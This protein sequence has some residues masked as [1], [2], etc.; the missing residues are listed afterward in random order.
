MQLSLTRVIGEKAEHL[1]HLG[2]THGS[3]CRFFFYRADLLPD[4]PTDLIATKSASTYLEI[5][6]KHPKKT[7]VK[8]GT[9]ISNPLTRYLLIL[10]KDTMIVFDKTLEVTDKKPYNITNLVPYATY[11]VNVTA[12]NSEGFGRSTTATFRTAE[13]GEFISVFVYTYRLLLH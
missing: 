13:D 5:S 8:L 9:N 10:L 7:G 3:I 12:G 1:F 2:A 6:W 11:K 4:K